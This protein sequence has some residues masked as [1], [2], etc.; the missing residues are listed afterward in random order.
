MQWNA[1]DIKGRNGLLHVF[2]VK[3]MV[4]SFV[5]GLNTEDVD[6]EAYYATIMDDVFVAHLVW[7]SRPRTEVGS[8]RQR[9]S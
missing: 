4:F 5:W 1:M 9:Q 6:V 3:I 2:R 8:Q 7:P